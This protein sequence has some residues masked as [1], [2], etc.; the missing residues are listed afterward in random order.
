MKVTFNKYL[1]RN[2]L[3][4]EEPGGAATSVSGRRSKRQR[5]GW[6]ALPSWRGDPEHAEAEREHGVVADQ[7]EQVKQSMVAH[8]F[9]GFA[10]L[11]V[12]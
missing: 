1:P 12:V 7:F 10:V 3:C 5:K 2:E 8:L 4:Q 11:G 6:G 9:D